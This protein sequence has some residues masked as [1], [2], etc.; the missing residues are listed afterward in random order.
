MPR[1]AEVLVHVVGGFLGSGKTTLLE[2]LLAFDVARG[3]RPGVVENELGE[4]DVDGRLLHEGHGHP[5]LEVVGLAGGCVCCDQSEELGRVVTEMAKARSRTSVFVETTGLASLD[6][7]VS[8]LEEA[9]GETPGVRLGRVVGVVDATR[10]ADVVAKWEAGKGH[11][12][13]AEVVLVN[14]ADLASRDQLRR[15]VAIAKKLAPRGEVH[16]TSF[17][18]VAPERILGRA[19]RRDARRV[20]RSPR[21]TDSTRGFSTS[22]FFVTR[23]VDM[24]KLERLVRRYPRAL[25][26]LK[27]LVAVPD[28]PRA[29][30][31][32]WTGTSFVAKPYPHPVERPYL[33]AIGRRLPWDRFLDAVADCLVRV[34]PRPRK[35]AQPRPRAR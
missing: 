16:V 22:S 31:V 10:I 23:P 33:V 12:K 4:A 25:V 26:R 32:Q 9:L 13:P 11:L 15:A 30:E 19:F 17:A 29:H 27:G 2:R 35:R 20:R 1:N 21:I 28:D 7:A 14:K 6:Q 8:T 34:L 18:D 24:T 5:S 3:G